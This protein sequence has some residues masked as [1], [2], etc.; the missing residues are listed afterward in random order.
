MRFAY[1]G[2]GAILGNLRPK[3]L[4]VDLHSITSRERYFIFATAYRLILENTQLS[5]QCASPCEKT[6]RILN[7]TSYLRPLPMLMKH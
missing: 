7:L 2:M 5:V 6:G 4:E 3:Y 1:D